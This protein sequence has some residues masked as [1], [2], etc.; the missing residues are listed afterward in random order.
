MKILLDIPDWAMDGVIRLLSNA[1]LVA[2][3]EPG[4]DQPFFVKVERC[5]QCGECCLDV[6]EKGPF[7]CDDEGKCVKLVKRTDGKWD[8]TA[9]RLFPFTCILPPK[10]KRAEEIGCSITFEKQK[11]KVD[12]R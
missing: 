12:G 9:G 10:G 4:R 3:K 8:C 1:E 6:G 11:G 7:G 2:Y 5:N